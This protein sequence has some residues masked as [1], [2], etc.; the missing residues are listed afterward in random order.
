[1]LG[2]N[3]QLDHVRIA[4]NSAAV[5]VEE[6]SMTLAHDAQ[7]RGHFANFGAKL[8]RLELDIALEGEGAE[9]HLSGV[10]VLSGDVHADVTTHVTHAVGQTQS[11]Q[12][13]KKVAGGRA[14]R[15][16]IRAR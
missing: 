1:M 14:P 16:S 8:S 10:S 2:R 12:L 15:P 13:F 11:T 3:A 5:Q 4:P 7:Y 6:I 9:A